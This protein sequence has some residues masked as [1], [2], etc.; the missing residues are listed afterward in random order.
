MVKRKSLIILVALSLG[1]V[2]FWGEELARVALQEGLSRSLQMPVGIRRLSFSTRDIT[3]HGVSIF[4]SRSAP[5][6][7]VIRRLRIEGS[8]FST[9]GRWFFTRSWKEGTQ[10]TLKVTGLTLSAGGVPLQAGGRVTVTAGPKKPVLCEGWL[11]LDHPMFRGEIELSGR[12]LQ[13]VL[14]GWV[15][16]PGFGRRR[17][18][19]QFLLGREGIALRRMEIQGGWS[20]DGSVSMPGGSGWKGELQVT[21]PD[22]RY[23]V[24]VEPLADGRIQA[25][26]W[27]HREGEPPQRVSAAWKVR[28]SRLELQADLLG[29]EAKLGGV[30]ELKPPHAVEL[31]M[32]LRQLDVEELLHWYLPGVVGS[33]V[34]GRVEGQV[35]LSGSAQRP[36]SAGELVSQEGSFGALKFSA[37]RLRFDGQGP[38]LRIHD[39]QIVKPRGVVSMEGMVDLRR[40]GQQ[41][42]LKHIQLH[43]LEPGVELMGLEVSAAPGGSGVRL[44]RADAEE[45]APRVGMTYRMDDTMPQEPVARQD[46]DVEYPLSSQEHVNF[47]VHGEEEILSVE[48]RRKF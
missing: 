14:Y 28:R 11:T 9:L 16:G 39:S 18:V 29:E 46:L 5:A 40:I 19:S 45:G 12:V 47:R 24:R 6:P 10:E 30:V 23:R 3:L 31:K 20:A 4:S 36:V 27:M 15:E 22:Q 17:F 26:A 37:I 13:P 2:L 41:D 35:T 33:P 7:V 21:S 43:S 48:H 1:L 32:E 25:V 42:F 8:P 38:V 44:G 34:S